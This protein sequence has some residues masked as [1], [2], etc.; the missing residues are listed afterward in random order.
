MKIVKVSIFFLLV[1]TLLPMTL[2][3]TSFYEGDYFLMGR[4]AGTLPII[5]LI[6]PPDGTEQS[7][8]IV[9]FVFSVSDDETITSCSLV[10][11]DGTYTTLS[12]ITKNQETTIEIVGI[13]SGHPLHRDNLRW[14][15]T[16]IDS[17][18]T[19]GSS[20]IRNLDTDDNWIW[21]GGN[22]GGTTPTTEEIGC[23]T[24]SK[25]DEILNKWLNNLGVD[26]NTLDTYLNKWL[27]QEGCS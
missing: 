20:E 9:N 16:C 8:G 26:L 2:A 17:F 21:G 24:L 14:R 5:T 10:Y 13:N 22:G 12:P 6:S 1:L 4:Q 18:L 25:F 27:T 19:T 23:V 11:N 7:G 3:K 15:I